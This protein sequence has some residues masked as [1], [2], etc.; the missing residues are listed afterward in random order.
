VKFTLL[1]LSLIL[2]QNSQGQPKVFQDSLAQ[3]SYLLYGSTVLNKE[4]QTTKV[5]GSQAT[6]F[7]IKKSERT[8][9]VTARHAVT[10]FID[11]AAKRNEFPENYNVY[12]HYSDPFN[13]I[14]IPPFWVTDKSKIKVGLKSPDI[15]VYEVTDKL[16]D[17]P[18]SIVDLDDKHSDFTSA[19]SRYAEIRLCGFPENMNRIENERIQ[20][21]PPYMFTTKNFI[22]TENFINQI[23]NERGIDSFRYEIQIKD[24]RVNLGLAGFSGA[25]V[26]IKS[27][28]GKWEFLGILVAINQIRN[29]IYV[30][31]R[32]WILA[33]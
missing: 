25:P 16:N 21:S 15:F 12:S 23:G 10:N 30:A 20:I 18:I 32:N 3:F 29:S 28:E 19:N 33:E 26:F 5:Q 22:I 4:N 14:P 11:K 8:Y 31:K 7:F 13:F 1:L 9:F 6:G 27:R 2:F 17:F 24:W